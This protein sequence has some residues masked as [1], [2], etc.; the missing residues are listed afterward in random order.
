MI[1]HLTLEKNGVTRPLAFG[2]T[3][4]VNAGFV[5]RNQDEV[6]KHV[7]ELAAKGI[8]AP[9]ST[10]SLYPVLCRNLITDSSIEV[11]GSKTSGEVEYV[12]LIENEK[13]VYVGLGSD[14]TDRHLEETDIPRAKQ[15]CPNIISNTV[16]P[17]DEA[18]AHW[19]ELVMQ[20]SVIRD[21]SRIDYQ[22]GKL[23]L[24]LTPAQLMDFVRSKIGGPL[25][26]TIIYSGTVGM[27][28]D[29]FVF[30]RRFEATLKD[31]V[32]N[33]RLDLA[34]DVLPLSYMSEQYE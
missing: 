29:G 27:K 21:D 1:A 34:Y 4:M 19:D 31:P 20:S 13:N 15:I 8:P 12:L 2:F 5:G 23:E 17:L 10:P 24:I 22:E 3:R 6:Q 30:G 11:L 9:S 32:L 25:D 26:N 33:R 14:H 7:K 18:E 16:W 28:T